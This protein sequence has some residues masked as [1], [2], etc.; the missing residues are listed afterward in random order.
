MRWNI[1]IMWR[2]RFSVK[3]EKDGKTKIR[4]VNPDKSFE[5]LG[6][7][8]SMGSNSM[9]SSMMGTDV[10]YEMPENTSLYENQYEVKAGRWPENYNECVVVLDFRWRYQRFYALYTGTS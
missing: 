10:F 2:R 1:L 4:Q 9:M 5:A 6:F 3:E 7:G 8:S